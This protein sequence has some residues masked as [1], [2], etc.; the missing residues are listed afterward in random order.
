MFKEQKEKTLY[1]NKR[2]IYVVVLLITVMIIFSS[3]L[4]SNSQWERMRLITDANL[5][6]ASQDVNEIM[7]SA[8]FT[9]NTLI[10]NPYFVNI[11]NTN[12]STMSE[13]YFATQDLDM[14]LSGASL[15]Y[16]NECSIVVYHNNQSLFNNKYSQKMSSLETNIYNRVRKIDVSQTLWDD[17][18]DNFYLYKT[19]LDSNTVSLIIKFTIPKKI[20]DVS[21]KKF[22]VLTNE[23]SSVENNVTVGEDDVSSEYVL[24]SKLYNGQWLTVSLP[25]KLKFNIYILNMYKYILV[26]LGVIILFIAFFYLAMFS[27]NK[28]IAKYLDEM[29]LKGRIAVTDTFFSKT[30]VLYPFYKKIGELVDEIDII[31][32]QTIKMQ[33][34]KNL[35]ELNYIQSQMNPHI[36][37][38]TLGIIKWKSIKLSPDIA[39]IIDALADY[40]RSCISDYNNII[41]F[42]EEIELI[43]KFIVLVETTGKNKVD[44]SVDIDRDLYSLKTVRHI[45]QP[46]VENSVLHGLKNIENPCIRVR[47]KKESE[48]IT[49]KIYDN[50]RGISD[51]DINRIM[52]NTYVSKYKSFGIKN[53]MQRIKLFYGEECKLRVE[54]SY[55][56]Y[57]EFTIEIPLPS[58]GV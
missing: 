26:L 49:I 54:S 39:Y 4:I 42:S 7:D 32:R 51:E 6:K 16:N 25:K 13:N 12:Y 20:I 24:C 56:E 29:L 17:D 23:N 58:D 50:G 36:L 30:D 35:I 40:Y 53:T 43:K 33:K 19:N 22:E 27:F 44:F 5:K 2:L 34:E 15:L 28:S 9:C 52:T 48:T 47:I 55:G 11:Y 31:H 18:D 8:L 21:V 57:T 45:I 10:S 41:T 37:Y 3:I 1:L 38:N 46:F 14:L